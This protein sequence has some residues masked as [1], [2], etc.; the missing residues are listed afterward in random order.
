MLLL[1]PYEMHFN[2]N[3]TLS[4]KACQTFYMK[5]VKCYH[6]QNNKSDENNE[7]SLHNCQHSSLKYMLK[8]K[9][10]LRH[11]HIF[12]LPCFLTDDDEDIFN[13]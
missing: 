11:L 9:I 1:V 10:K 5:H 3:I 6:I 2:I 7:S 4:N 13:T 8:N 12:F